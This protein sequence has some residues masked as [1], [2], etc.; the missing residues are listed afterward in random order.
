M[1]NDVNVR[2]K[3]SIYPEDRIF[4]GFICRKG[5]E[6]KLFWLGLFSEYI[7]QMGT[8]ALH[9]LIPQQQQQQEDCL[10]GATGC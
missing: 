4:L 8:N 3:E 5:Q 9:Y 10:L 2:T 6:Y 7:G 1:F